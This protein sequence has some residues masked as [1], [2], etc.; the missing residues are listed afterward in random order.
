MATTYEWNCKTVDVY[1]TEG[2]YTDV[3]YNVH[4]ILTGTSEEVDGE[5]NPYTAT[6]IGTQVLDTSEITDFIP[7]EELTNEEIANWTKAAMGEE[8]VTELEASLQNTIDSL[9][10]PTSVTITIGGVKV[11]KYYFR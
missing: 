6:S 1:P 5:G 11:K 2:D 7:V 4:W 10:T 9:I 8:Q 3:V